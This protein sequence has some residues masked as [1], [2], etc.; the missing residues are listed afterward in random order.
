MG[1]ASKWKGKVKIPKPRPY[2]RE[3]VVQKFEIFMLNIEQYFQAIGITLEEAQLNQA[4]MF[5]FDN[6]KVWW[7]TKYLEVQE[8]KC[9]INTWEELKQELKVHFYLENVDYM[10]R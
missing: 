2:I 1:G 7:R 4:T 10:M 9:Q 6:A 5:L 8:G 3:R